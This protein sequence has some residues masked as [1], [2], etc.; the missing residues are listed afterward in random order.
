MPNFGISAETEILPNFFIGQNRK[1]SFGH[2]LAASNIQTR[3]W[4]VF[5]RQAAAV[6]VPPSPLLARTEWSVVLLLLCLSWPKVRHASNLIPVN[7]C[8]YYERRDGRWQREIKGEQQTSGTPRNFRP[9]QPPNSLR[10]Q[11]WPHIWNQW[12]LTCVAI[13]AG[14]NVKRSTRTEGRATDAAPVVVW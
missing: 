6:A 5:R 11:I 9:L 7:Q 4:I 14:N 12:P 1:T 13:V 10:G 3:H 2:S 8:G